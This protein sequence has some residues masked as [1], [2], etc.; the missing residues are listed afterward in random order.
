MTRT[1]IASVSASLLLAL[2]CLSCSK[3]QKG[4]LYQWESGLAFGSSVLNVE[5]SADDE[6][7]I[8][9]PVYRGSESVDIA[10]LTLQFD[11]SEKGGA[12]AEW[13]DSDPAGIFSLI[14]RRLIFADG[15][16]TAYAQIRFNSLDKMGIGKKYRMR[17]S[18]GDGTLSP[19]EKGEVV[20]TASRRLTFK[21]IGTCLWTD[22]CVFD[23]TYEAEVYKAEEA[24][25]YRVMDPYTEG[26]RA[27]DYADSGW[28]GTPSEYVQFTVRDDGSIY[29][30]PFCT[31]MN[32]QGKYPAYAYYPSE[33]QWGKDFSSFDAMNKKISD[34][35]F[36]L[37]PVYCLPSFQY[38]FLNDGA[39]QLT[40]VLK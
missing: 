32:V 3:E 21:S 34:K 12:S 27:E 7:Q 9:V 30:E 8:L 28:L 15:S 1:H 35:E 25:I 24:E 36:Q 39:Y 4:E 23:G 6:N 13:V 19:S 40:M 33:Y 17:L 11:A 22:R 20:I 5:L 29:Y 38:G 14:A 26:L 10:V 31:G 16:Y 18:L 37:Y 2:V